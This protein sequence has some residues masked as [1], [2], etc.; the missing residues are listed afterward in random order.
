MEYM[1]DIHVIRADPLA[2]RKNLARRQEAGV[3]E[4]LDALIQADASY[5][6]VLQEL[7]LL[8][9]RRNQLNES[10]VQAKSKGLD[11]QDLIVQAKEFPVRIKE[12][13]SKS[14]ALKEIVDRSLAR[15]PNLLHESVPFGHSEADNQV[16]R[17]KGR[18]FTPRFD[19]K[20]HGQIAV[21]LGG[22]E[23]ERA[24]NLSGTGFFMLK[25]SLARLDFALQRFALDFL[26]KQGFSIIQPP[27]LM[28]RRPYEGVTDLEDFEKVMYK[29]EGEDLYLSA[30]SEHAL[31]G[32]LNGAILD[33]KELPL[34]WAACTPCFRREVGRHG[35][36]ERGF[37]RVHQFNKVE[38]VVVCN[39]KD[40]WKWHE[41][42]LKNTEAL[43]S[44][45][46]IPYRTV[47]VCTGDIGIVA[48]KKYDVQGWSPREQKYFELAS[49]S[50]CT[51]YQTVRS[52]IK[53]RLLS[54]EKEYPHSLNATAIATTRM[55]R[56]L[57]E[58]HQTKEGRV[59]IPNVLRKYLN[60]VKELARPS[61]S[62][63]VKRRSRKRVKAGR[64]RI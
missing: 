14:A 27:L 23:F 57:L 64:K 44:A 20:H 22:A 33:E 32:L 28:R 5:R 25:D 3:L 21:A 52:S 34:C 26:S 16:V 36:D 55:L 60:G 45:L 51:S 49:I 47:N 31:M 56:A 62:K 61:P 12:L 37:F 7:E 46:K 4:R 17:V 24:V 30:T 2:V 6:S 42:L 58:N 9:M 8:R 40:S 18:P 43:F 53:Y 38:Q 10:I 11:V 48:A 35:L 13:E 39:Q 1:L 50:N 29:V 15:V 19:L 63:H 54:G 59:K 41:R